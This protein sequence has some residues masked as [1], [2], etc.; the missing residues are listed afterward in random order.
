MRQFT[1]KLGIF[2][3]AM[4]FSIGISILVYLFMNEYEFLF[5]LQGVESL[6]GLASAF[7]GSGITIVGIYWTLQHESS[8]NRRRDMKQVISDKT[9]HRITHMPKITVAFEALDTFPDDIER[10]GT[11]RVYSLDAIQTDEQPIMSKFRMTVRNHGFGY[12]AEFITSFAYEDSPS[13]STQ[14]TDFLFVDSDQSAVTY[15]KVHYLPLAVDEKR[16]V[17]FNM[18]YKDV[19]EYNY[20][21][22][23]S[24]NLMGD[25]YMEDGVKI[26][27]TSLHDFPGTSG[28]QVYEPIGHYNEVNSG[29]LETIKLY[30]SKI[31]YGNFELL[32]Y[33]TIIT[34]SIKPVLN[35]FYMR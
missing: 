4:I 6:M 12:A 31:Y 18:T 26:E 19:F 14:D 22:I 16:T 13:L 30:R 34:R 29:D 9:E 23:K 10:N 8:T 28:H 1:K 32:D 11:F 35:K 27:S 3:V 24:F 20:S 25:S 17:N 7:L 33:P 2:A 15:V 5:S 21:Y